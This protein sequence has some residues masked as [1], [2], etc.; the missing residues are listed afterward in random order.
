M[1]ASFNI[2]LVNPLSPSP[3]VAIDVNSKS[4]LINSVYFFPTI[5]KTSDILNAVINFQN[6]ITDIQK[7]AAY[8]FA[9]NK[10]LFHFYTLYS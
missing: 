4:F 6:L 7:Y 3:S 9:K 8:R 5:N 10:H 1:T 2:H